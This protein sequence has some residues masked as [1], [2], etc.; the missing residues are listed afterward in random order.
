[1]QKMTEEGGFFAAI[2]SA[3]CT[4]NPMHIYPIPLQVEKNRKLQSLIQL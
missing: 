3:L 1:M 4:L 2:F